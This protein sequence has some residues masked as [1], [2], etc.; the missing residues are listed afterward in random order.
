MVMGCTLANH[1]RLPMHLS[2]ARGKVY[3]PDGAIFGPFELCVWAKRSSVIVLG[4]SRV[5]VCL[6]RRFQWVSVCLRWALKG[7]RRAA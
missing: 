6:F 2:A 3:L 1:K 5:F 4:Q 7:V